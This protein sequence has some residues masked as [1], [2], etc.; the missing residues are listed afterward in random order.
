MTMSTAL[1]AVR[2]DILVHVP[3]QRAFKVFTERFD[4]W[5]P[6]S[7]HI[8][9]ADMGEAV[10][11]PRAGGRWY[12]RGVDGS[13]CDWGRVL[14]WDPPHRL[15]LS[16]AITPQWAVEPDPERASEVHVSFEPEGDGATR[17]RIEHR[18]LER[19]GE[20]AAQMHDAVSREGG[21]GGLL[22]LFA[23]YAADESKSSEQELM[24]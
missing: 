9:A 20:G 2:R 6:R 11:E 12:E 4:A 18:H 3:Q 14:D 15:A 23:G 13:E 10:I 24:Q 19:H 1:D 17:V 7:H 16:W 8:G 22:D 21:W 5:W